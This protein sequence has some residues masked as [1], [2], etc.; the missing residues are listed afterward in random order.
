VY[1]SNTRTVVTNNLI[2]SLIWVQFVLS[3]LLPK[4]WRFI[5]QK[6][7]FRRKKASPYYLPT[8]CNVCYKYFSKCF[9]FS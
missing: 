7:V 3:K 4:N 1:V 6:V 5:L 2:T 9:T 8:I